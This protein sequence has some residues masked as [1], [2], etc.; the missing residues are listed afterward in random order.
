MQSSNTFSILF[1]V[2]S[3][4]AINN[5]TPLYARVTINGKRAN[6]SL[7]LKADI[8]TWDSERQRAKGT[9]EAS[10]ALNTY[11]D[12][13]HA[14]LVH[15]YQ[16][17]KFK[18]Q[19]IT[20]KLLKVTYLGE[21]EQSKTLQDILKY[22]RK[23]IEAT[24]TKGTLRNFSVTEGYL[25]KYL[26]NRL[27]TSD[28]YLKHLNY[29]FICDFEQ[30]LHTY[31]PKGHPKEMGHNTVMKHIQRFRKIITLGFHLEWLTKD[32]FLRWKPTF[33]KTERAFL[34]EN[35][36]ANIQSYDFKIERLDRVRDLFV[37][38]CFTGICYVDLMQLTKE[39]ITIGIDGHH[40]IF[41]H[42]QKTKS[43][44]KVPLLQK[45]QE[46]IIKYEQHPMT[47][48]SKTL[49]PVISNEKVNFYLK[50]IASA[51]GITKNLTFHMARHT[52]ATTVT[53]S[54]GV[55]IETVSKLLG[56][57]KIAS[58]QIYARVIERKVSD[59]M[60]VLKSKLHIKSKR[61]HLS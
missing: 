28:I 59:D 47:L 12:K 55:P 57:T 3:S 42:R 41:T 44:V 8:R 20:A 32:P 40:W 25:N 9:N 53:L 22:H 17:L 24:L 54:N 4:R 1:W 11:L 29:K 48:V 30:Y 16:D 49:F 46:L 6:I 50:E 45:A 7:K 37:F 10:R 58:T 13:V 43:P 26:K 18:E 23:K 56:H 2:Y 31:W 5:L 34:S 33:E 39:S 61:N 19:L 15:N 51:C 52:F 21:G 36:L 60:E 14:K 38:S 35:E 27:K